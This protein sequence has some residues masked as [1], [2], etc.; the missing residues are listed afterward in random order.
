[1]VDRLG[2]GD[3]DFYTKSDVMFSLSKRV[4]ALSTKVLG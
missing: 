3:I 2:D 4:M 1:M